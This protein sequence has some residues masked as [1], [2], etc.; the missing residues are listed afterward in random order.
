[1]LRP[2]AEIRPV[3]EAQ[4]NAKG[5]TKRL[6]GF[7]PQRENIIF[8]NLTFVVYTVLHISDI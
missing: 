5:L 2:E 8:A 6:S 3:V 4:R 1:M 7:A